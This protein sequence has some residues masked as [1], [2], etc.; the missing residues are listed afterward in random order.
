MKKTT[1]NNIRRM[2]LAGIFSA[3][4][5]AMTVVPYTGYINYGGLAELTTLHAITIIGACCLTPVYGATVGGVWG[6]TCV[7]RA[8][9]MSS[10]SA[11]VPFINPI[12]SLL[13]RLLVGLFASLVFSGLKKTKCPLYVNAVIASVVGSLTNTVFVLTFYSLFNQADAG[14]MGIIKTI[15]VTLGTFNGLIELGMAI[16]I[17]PPVIVALNKSIYKN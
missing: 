7:I 5:I 15:I 2:V 11:F 13:P 17:V 8:I 1:S 14:F 16:V 3:I 6:A 9:A 12:V 4:I 10:N